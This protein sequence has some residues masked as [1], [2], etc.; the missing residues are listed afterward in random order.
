MHALK[1]GIRWRIARPCT[2]ARLRMR[3]GLRPGR[4][5]L[6]QESTQLQTHELECSI[7][8]SATI[9]VAMVG[10]SLT[11]ADAENTYPAAHSLGTWSAAAVLNENAISNIAVWLLVRPANSPDFELGQASPRFTQDSMHQPG[12]APTVFNF[13]LSPSANIPTVTLLPSS[14]SGCAGPLATQHGVNNDLRGVSCSLVHS[15]SAPLET[16]L[17]CL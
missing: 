2:V 6:C 12:F 13:K 7:N 14:L 16:H 10:L 4:L 5:S 8:I 17:S 3:T 1:F 15:P 9:S 11:H